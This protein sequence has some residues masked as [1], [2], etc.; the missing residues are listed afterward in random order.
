MAN[1]HIIR[2]IFVSASVRCLLAKLIYF[3]HLPSVID[4]GSSEINNDSDCDLESTDS[5]WTDISEL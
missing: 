1:S 3:V 5:E 2:R 4:S